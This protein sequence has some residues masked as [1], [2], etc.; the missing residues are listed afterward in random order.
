ME[1]VK[2]QGDVELYSRLDSSY[3]TEDENSEVSKSSI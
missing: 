1:N 3:P 2:D